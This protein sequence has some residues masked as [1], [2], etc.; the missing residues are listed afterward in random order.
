M[1]TKLFIDS[2][3]SSLVSL[4]KIQNLPLLS[5]RSVITPYL[6][7]VHFFESASLNIKDLVVGPVDE[8]VAL[9][10]EDLEPS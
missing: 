3:S 7:W 5:F 10:L 9:I 6:N 8:L 1:E 4:V 2:L